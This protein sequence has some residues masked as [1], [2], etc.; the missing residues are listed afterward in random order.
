MKINPTFQ[1][2]KIPDFHGT[3]TLSPAGPLTICGGTISGCPSYSYVQES[4]SLFSTE[5]TIVNQES[6]TTS[7]QTAATATAEKTMGKEVRKVKTATKRSD[8]PNNEL[9]SV[10]LILPSYA[11]KH[12]AEIKQIIANKK[13]KLCCNKFYFD[14]FNNVEFNIA[15]TNSRNIKKMIVRTKL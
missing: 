15:Y 11:E 8:V 5:I 9:S 6:K 3:K 12:K 7:R 10:Y 2:A 14:I 1:A 13:T 4:D